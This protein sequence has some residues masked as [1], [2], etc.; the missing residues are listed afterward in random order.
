MASTAALAKIKQDL[1]IKHNELDADISDTI[2][3]CLSDLSICGV[4]NPDDSDV[5]ILS[6]V[7]LFCRANY[8]DD[9]GKASAYMDRYNALKSCLMMAAGYGGAAND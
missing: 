6:A 5:T 3:A 4:S 1:R 2:D 7:K 9:T 8:T